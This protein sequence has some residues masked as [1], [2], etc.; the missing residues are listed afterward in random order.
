MRCLNLLLKFC[1][2]YLYV[3]TLFYW[4]KIKTDIDLEQ[5]AYLLTGIGK[6]GGNVL[7]TEVTGWD[8]TYM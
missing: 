6:Y 4:W 7:G 3:I 1:I 5:P 8:Q 2:S